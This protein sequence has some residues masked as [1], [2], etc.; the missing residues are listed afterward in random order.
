MTLK[1]LKQATPSLNDLNI[2][3]KKI[4]AKKSPLLQEQ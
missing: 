1:Q 2:Q 4:K 3:I